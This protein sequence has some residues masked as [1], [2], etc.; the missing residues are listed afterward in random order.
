MSSVVPDSPA[1]RRQAYLLLV[2]TFLLWS[3][4]FIAVRALVGEMVPEALRLSPVEFVVARFVPVALFCL[5]WFAVLP[6]ARRE[7]RA[8][9]RERAGLVLLLGALNVWAYNLAFAAGHRRV[10]AGT[11]SLV[12]TLNPVLTFLLAVVVGLER[13]TLR[14][15]LGLAI[16]IA[17]LYV[18]V[19]HGAGRAIEPAYL[20]DALLLGLA[21]ASWATYTVLSKPLV[22]RWSP[23][24]LTFLT[25]GLGS[26]P[27]FV[28]LA[29][30]GA[31]RRKVALWGSGP[32]IAALFLGIGCTLVG[33]WLWYEALRRI[34]ASTAAAFVFLNPPLA[35]FFEWLWF[36]RVPAAGLYL[37]GAI[38]LAGVWMCVGPLRRAS[39][40]PGLP[41]PEPAG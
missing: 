4:S 10:P 16:A 41:D 39:R 21:P 38:V 27:S 28:P 20:R 11:G 29:L 18:V 40:D 26:L 7:A 8:I 25:L 13:A 36:G 23:V 17:G 1:A 15:A 34:P 32:W 2:V 3:N 12:I 35:L 6:S 33:F 22:G 9:L 31:F 37:G 5:G 24:H 19:V 30:D 14:K